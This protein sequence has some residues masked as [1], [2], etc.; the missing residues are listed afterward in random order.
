MKRY[1]MMSILIAVI[2]N[3]LIGC[4]ETA[5]KNSENETGN[6][7]TAEQ[8]GEMEQSEYD[9]MTTKSDE[10]KME[11]STEAIT[12]EAEMTT[13]T[14]TS[15]TEITTATTTTTITATTST[16]ATTT[17]TEAT[18][19]TTKQTQS[20]TVTSSVS[21]TTTAPMEPETKPTLV[22]DGN[23]YE[24]S[25]GVGDAMYDITMTSSSMEEF[26]L[27]DI[28][29]EKELIVLNF[30]FSGCGPCRSEFPYMEEAYQM[31]K[32]K[33]EIIA[34]NPVDTSYVIEQ[35]RLENALSFKMAYCSW[36]FVDVFGVEYYP[37]SIYID[38][39]GTIC[40]MEVGALTS[41]S[42]FEDVFSLFTGEDYQQIIYQ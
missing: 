16:V 41:T 36:D 42:A 2:M 34:V 18:T 28:L 39:Y 31:Y 33:I 13:S 12:T 35:F 14:E 6:I 38:R 20:E 37:T 27:S 11:I 1:L 15:T 23:I 10:T 19:T 22:M 40:K 26:T 5:F 4:Q 9:E 29:E 21:E 30:W 25:L 24:Q 17:T 3:I 32:D 8:S 7:P